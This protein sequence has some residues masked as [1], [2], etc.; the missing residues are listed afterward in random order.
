MNGTGAVRCWGLN[1]YGQLGNGGTSNVLNPPSSDVLTGVAQIA[2]GYAHTCALMS[3][4]GGVR[5]WGWNVYGQLGNGGSSNVLSPPSISV[6]AGV[7]QIA[8]GQYHT[9]ALIS[10]TGG[11]RCWGS[12]TYGQLGNGRTSDVLFSLPTFIFI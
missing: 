9:C 4:A 5:C 7:A 8:A 2:A 3:V 10:G 12:N 6:G 11:L 1:N